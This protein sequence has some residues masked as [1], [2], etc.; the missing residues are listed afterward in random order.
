MKTDVQ[1]WQRVAQ[2]LLEW[3]TW[4]RKVVETI[5][6]R[7]PFS[8]QLYTGESH[9]SNRDFTDTYQI[10]IHQTIQKRNILVDKQAHK[11]PVNKHTNTQ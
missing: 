10:P 3:E 9:N 7:I 11:Y 8:R 4:Q 6:T 5:K 2:F 1:C